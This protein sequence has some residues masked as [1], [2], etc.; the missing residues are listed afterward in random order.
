MNL[1]YA[2]IV[3]TLVALS[4]PLSDPAQA[5]KQ[6]ITRVFRPQERLGQRSALASQSSLVLKNL[7]FLLLRREGEAMLGPA[8][9]KPGPI[10]PSNG[11]S[12][13][14]SNKS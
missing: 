6:T 7:I 14:T 10:S 1:F 9:P 3:L 5:V 4:D 13:S 12:A 11:V 2:A 8:T